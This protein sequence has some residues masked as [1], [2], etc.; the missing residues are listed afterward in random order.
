MAVRN[1]TRSK[2]TVQAQARILSS[3]EAAHGRSGPYMRNRA[4]TQ[5]T[6]EVDRLILSVRSKWPVQAHARI[7]SGGET[8]HGRSGPYRRNRAK[9]QCTVEVDRQQVCVGRSVQK[10]KAQGG[11]PAW[12]GKPGASIGGVD[13]RTGAEVRAVS[14]SVEGGATE[15]KPTPVNGGPPPPGGPPWP[16]PASHG[17]GSAS[18][19]HLATVSSSARQLSTL[20]EVDPHLKHRNSVG[21]CWLRTGLRM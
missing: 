21:P 4:K 20:C 10:E 12:L 1:R 14:P 11:A 9:T 3:G 13:F 19:T 16:I 6:V 2:W 7:L 15:G 8:A 18:S 5:C 17:A